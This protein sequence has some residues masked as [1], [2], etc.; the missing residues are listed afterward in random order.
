[1]FDRRRVGFRGTLTLARYLALPHL[2][3]S[4][5]GELEGEVDDALA[6]LGKARRV[7]MVTAHF[8]VLPSVLKRIAAVATLPEHTARQLAREARLEVCEPPI[9]LRGYQSSLAW[10]R[11]RRR[12]GASLA[13]RH[14]AQ[15]LAGRGGKGLRRRIAGVAW[16]LAAVADAHASPRVV[17]PSARLP[18]E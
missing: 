10:L 6:R 13:A 7:V 3:V 18:L 15:H 11:A 17:L 12:S 9:A 16:C 2:L 8:S 5:R 14:R 1:M 4:S